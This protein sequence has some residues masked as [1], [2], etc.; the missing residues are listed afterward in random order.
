MHAGRR[1]A[2]P[3]KAL[4]KAMIKRLARSK[5]VLGLY[6]A[7]TA[8]KLGGAKP[9]LILGRMLEI[10]RRLD[11][12]VLH[13]QAALAR[14]PGSSDLAQAYDRVLI[15]V[16][17]FDTAQALF[18][19][20]CTRPKKH[21]NALINFAKN[22]ENNEEYGLASL[23]WRA[24][25][26]LFPNRMDCH[27]G[28]ISTLTA[29][30][31]IAEA[32]KV[33]E[34]GKERFVAV[35]FQ[36]LEAR[37]WLAQDCYDRA[38]ELLESLAESFP[39][40]RAIGLAIANCLT[41]TGRY[42]QAERYL[43][44]LRERRQ[45]E[46]K[47]IDTCLAINA[48]RARRYDLAIKR[49]HLLAQTQPA[50][51]FYQTRYIDSLLDSGDVESARATLNAQNERDANSRFYCNALIKVLRAYNEIDTALEAVDQAF[52]RAKPGRYSVQ[53]RALLLK[54]K[55]G[56]L[57]RQ[58]QNSGDPELLQLT[59]QTLL[60]ARAPKYSD[61]ELDILLA[62]AS[63]ATNDTQ[64]A[65]D[66]QQALPNS[67]HAPLV[68]LNSWAKAND[69]DLAGAKALWQTQKQYHR[70]PHIAPCPPG[71][72][73]R[74]DALPLETTADE[75]RVFTAIR[76]EAW[77]L[78]WFLDYY[79]KLG[80]DRFFFVDNNSQDGSLAYLLSQ[81]DVHVFWTDQSYAAAY[82]GMQW[83]NQLTR[84]YG[85]DG[86]LIYVDV[87]EA[88]VYADVEN[89]N[90]RQ[91]TSA[92][93][94]YDEEALPG[95]MRDMFANAPE[96]NLAEGG[97]FDF[98]ERYPMFTPDITRYSIPSCPYIYVRGGARQS[99][100]WGEILTKTPL[101]RGGR[102]IAFLMSSHKISPARLSRFSAALL[103]FKLAGDYRQQFNRDQE[104][105][106]RMP[107]CQQRHRHYARVLEGTGAQQPLNLPNALRYQ[108]SQQLLEL[109][110]IQAPA[111]FGDGSASG[112]LIT[113]GA[114]L[115]AFQ[116]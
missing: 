63:L 70:I 11:R 13:Y 23:R 66:R 43:L 88:L 60:E 46:P 33:F 1:R 89:R 76:N 91:L 54:K 36:I 103:H 97:L 6:R 3:G 37:I 16:G 72:L 84:Q 113:N 71:S 87:D 10:E 7:L 94:A 41:E 8:L 30:Q 25:C 85:Q 9:D 27:A 78:P 28:L 100:G 19:D 42:D 15:Q 51:S 79:R 107:V 116:A 109:G 73:K 77:R 83:I 26:E 50:N 29:E 35:D 101:V 111:D 2:E 12:A 14:H 47:F 31:R 48:T 104:T 75:I 62:T 69:G 92:M 45:I 52:E 49:W 80:V 90:L 99:F 24:L 102:D 17:D 110:L 21:P 65:K 114:P 105:N 22:G 64:D 32:T 44:D 106:E 81:P 38:L 74:M 93:A 40:N 86:W 98:V 58:H 96:P 18:A 57:K 5:F 59:K 39:N 112:S 95:Y 53:H 115:L 61:L 67:L 20:L 34:Q 68:E 82:S 56:L 4:A 55:A 108:G